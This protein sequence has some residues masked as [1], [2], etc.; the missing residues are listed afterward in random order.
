MTGRLAPRLILL[1]LLGA[2]VLPFRAPLAADPPAPPPLPYRSSAIL[3]TDDDGMEWVHSVGTTSL[4]DGTVI[5]LGLLWGRRTLAWGNAHVH[6]GRFEGDVGPLDPARP[7]GVYRIEVRF[8]RHRQNPRRLESLRDLPESLTQPLWIRVGTVEGE[9]AERESERAWFQESLARLAQLR[10]SLAE[11]GMEESP[12]AAWSAHWREC[13]QAEAER[14]RQRWAATPLP[15]YDDAHRILDLL[16]GEQ[17]ALCDRLLLERGGSQSAP[18][19]IRPSDPAGEDPS[20]GGAETRSSSETLATL[21]TL[22]ESLQRVIEEREQMLTPQVAHDC[23]AQLRRM[24]DDVSIQAGR[25]RQGGTYAEWSSWSEGNFKP[26]L[27]ELRGRIAGVGERPSPMA[28]RFPEAVPLLAKAA[29]TLSRFWARHSLDLCEHH[30]VP[31]QQRFNYAA[32]EG[33]PDTESRT[34]AERLETQ[35]SD[36]DTLIAEARTPAQIDEAGLRADLEHSRQLLE[37]LDRCGVAGSDVGAWED[38]SESFLD[39]LL[40]FEMDLDRYEGSTVSERL[41][42]IRPL[43]AEVTLGLRRL[44]ARHAIA[45]YD[46]LGVPDSLRF[47]RHAYPAALGIL[48]DAL[49][50]IPPHDLRD[51]LAGAIDSLDEAAGTLTAPPR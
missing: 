21:D 2:T 4:P 13:V 27:S 20:G 37:A 11:I 16:C 6:D 8:D 24:R 32:V 50:R 42:G 44:W 41:P 31:A 26:R 43:W 9:A 35:L 18:C 51:R 25:A 28:R 30:A 19:R 7:C 29:E 40:G 38:W 12:G 34:Y 15:R 46:S 47:A 14:N 23:V 36:L 3:R 5:S 49:R 1:A 39:D 10:G 17:E 22:E 45:F 33:L 48:P